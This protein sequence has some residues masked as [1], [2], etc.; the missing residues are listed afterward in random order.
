[1]DPPKNARTS[2]VKVESDEA[3][4]NDT[5]RASS[6]HDN[7]PSFA[8]TGAQHPAAIH[9]NQLA[10][11]AAGQEIP[12]IF[13][14]SPDD[15]TTL[16]NTQPAPNNGAEQ[17]IPYLMASNYGDGGNYTYAYGQA[18]RDL[19]VP[20]PAQYGNAPTWALDGLRQADH[21][22]GTAGDGLT[23]NPQDIFND[24]KH[25]AASS[26]SG[27]NRGRATP[28]LLAPFE[29][30]PRRQAA[31]NDPTPSE[32][33]SMLNH[34]RQVASEDLSGFD[35]NSTNNNAPSFSDFASAFEFQGTMNNEQVT[36]DLLD[37]LG[38]DSTTA[39]Y[40]NPSDLLADFDFDNE[41]DNGQN[42]N[43]FKDFG[44]GNTAGQDSE[45]FMPGLGFGNT[46]ASERDRADSFDLSNRNNSGHNLADP[47]PLFDYGDNGSTGLGSSA[48]M[49]LSDFTTG[50]GLSDHT[51]AFDMSNFDS[52]MDTG[53]RA[54]NTTAGF[55]LGGTTTSASDASARAASQR[56]RNAT[57]AAEPWR[58]AVRLG[59]RPYDSMF[60]RSDWDP[61]YYTV[62]PSALHTSVPNQPANRSSLSTSRG[63][64][65]SPLTNP[66][67]STGT[68]SNAY[69]TVPRPGSA[70][71][72]PSSTGLAPAQNLGDSR[73]FHDQRD[74]FQGGPGIPRGSA[75]DPFTVNEW[76]N[77]QPSLGDLDVPNEFELR[78]GSALE[79]LRS[80]PRA[81]P[82]GRR[83]TFREALG[84]HDD[85]EAGGSDI[86][87]YKDP[88][89]DDEYVP[90][91]KAKKQKKSN[92]SNKPAKSS[93]K[94]AKPSRKPAARA[95]AASPSSS[96]NKEKEDPKQPRKLP[97]NRKMRAPRGKLMRPNQ[98]FWEK[99]CLA[100][101]Y[102]WRARHGIVPYGDIAEHVDPY[103]TGNGLQQALWKLRR[104][105]LAAALVVPPAPP[106]TRRGL[107]AGP[108]PRRGARA[109]PSSAP[110]APTPAEEGEDDEAEE[111]EEESEEEE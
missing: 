19:T 60:P 37:N 105:R 26:S 44:A 88:E 81:A 76:D 90:P 53:R 55:G 22:Y 61:P 92:K 83:R 12:F 46:S 89:S 15:P 36:S 74:F 35:F 20:Q 101:E 21:G 49:G 14:T 108:P 97:M 51:A 99:C 75:F 8:I 68:L 64:A 17:E 77:S 9:A 73:Q 38:F 78:R 3:A 29:Y 33:A 30:T 32:F 2:S 59:N 16:R 110:A 4:A 27:N 79:Q 94:P 72:R 65:Y 11:N 111:S 25:T 28:T 23:C 100:F 71:S 10:P 31:T 95:P 52:P 7:Q 42:S 50:P 45:D 103:C 47:I 109:G 24:S 56:R 82:T 62:N 66:Y 93:T 13:V 104:K 6:S 18:N 102:E 98:D 41:A 80:A 1:M 96:P 40:Q 39:T 86:Y 106:Q 57:R 84:E 5:H 58:D 48:S 87:V 34:R 54:S 70:T 91:T 107:L 67:A 69:L 85:D 43:D 63:R